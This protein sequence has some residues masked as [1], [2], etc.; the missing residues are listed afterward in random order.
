MN[1]VHELHTLEWFVGCSESVAATPEK[2]VP[3]IVP[4]AVQLD[5]ARAHGWPEPAYDPDVTKYRWMEDAHWTYRTVLPTIDVRAGARLFFVCGGVD[6]AFDVRLNGRVLHVQEGMFTPFEIDLSDAARAGDVLE[7]RVHPAPK[8]CRS[9]D[10]VEA[11]QSVKPTVSYE[12]DFHPRLIPLGIWQETGLAVRPAMH[13]KRAETRAYLNDDCTAARIEL[14]V[15]VSQTGGTLRWRFVDPDGATIFERMCTVDSTNVMSAQMLANPRLWWPNGQGEPALY[16]SMVE[17]GRRIFGKGANWVS[18]EIFLGRATR[19]TYE[20][21][22]TLAHDSNFNLLRCWGGAGI[23]KEAF[24][25]LCDELGLLVWQEFPLACNRYEGTPE[26]LDVLDRESRSILLQLRGH[27]CLALWCGGNELFNNW[28]KMTD[29][30]LALRLLN[31]NCYDLDRE[32]PFLM[33]SPMSGMAHGGYFFRRGDGAEVYQYFA[34]SKNTAYTEFGVTGSASADLLR[35]IIPVNELWPPQPGTQWQTRHALAAWQPDSW[36][37]L[38]TIRHYFGEPQT[39]EQ[40]VEWSQWLQAEGYKAIFEEARRQKPV[41]AMALNWVLNEPWP[42][43]ANNS[44]VSWPCEP[45]PAMAAVAASCRS[46]LASARIPKFAWRAGESFSV[47]LWLLNDAP[48]MI[49]PGCIEAWVHVGGQSLRA[50]EWQHP[51]AAAGVNVQGPTLRIMLPQAAADR[52][53]DRLELELRHLDA[54]ERTSRYVLRY[55]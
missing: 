5:W 32:R 37:D 51:A 8:S 52:H 30:D 14:G 47:E 45:K 38:H 42:T 27:A 4:G 7:V 20:P 6:Y 12:W 35:R 40:M 15:H 23:Q 10:R 54:P 41:C 55:R 25:D 39:L 21:L 11:N 24:F 17:H 13:M 43:A 18:P 1:A 19:A 36:L 22:L 34:Q 46:V 50:L 49:T 28:S 3:A 33:T 48:E 9:G 2:F 53:A 31:R 26:Y 29:Q 16:T 44:L